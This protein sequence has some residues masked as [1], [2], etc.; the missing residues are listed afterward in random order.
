[1]LPA[2]LH[3]V[4]IDLCYDRPRLRALFVGYELHDALGD[5][6]VSGDDEHVRLIGF[7]LVQ[8]GFVALDAVSRLVPSGLSIDDAVLIEAFPP[9][10]ARPLR[11]ADAGGLRFR[12]RDGRLA[13]APE[14]AVP[15]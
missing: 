11:W 5:A 7:D 6:Y 4:A 12:L 8:G 10:D 14:L 1:M 13:D 15:A 3:D 2:A 9:V